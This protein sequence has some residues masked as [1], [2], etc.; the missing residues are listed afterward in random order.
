VDA[1]VGNL[2]QCNMEVED[3]YIAKTSL[4]YFCLWIFK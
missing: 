2:V 4:S 1:F 3:W